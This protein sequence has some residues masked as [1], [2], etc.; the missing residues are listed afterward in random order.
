MHE[1]PRK[2]SSRLALVMLGISVVFGS[3]VA[4]D[5]KGRV[6]GT[7]TASDAQPV[8]G[9]TITMQSSSETESTLS[10]TKG[11][12]AFVS[13]IPDSYVLTV[14]REGYHDETRLDVSVQAD[15]VKDESVTLESQIS[16][17]GHVTARSHSSLVQ[18]GA[19]SD[20]YSL[21]TNQQAV[22]H[23]FGGGN[24]RDSI[25]SSLS[26][27]PGVLVP[28][29]QAPGW[30]QSVL[31]RGG[32]YIQTGYEYDGVPLNRAFDQY[33]ATPLSSL[34]TQEIQAYI[35]GAPIDQ[36]TEGIGGY[37]NQVIKSGS[38]PNS[39]T[40]DVGLGGPAYYNKTALEFSGANGP[41]K[42]F[43]YYIGLSGM[44]FSQ[45]IID[46]SN[47]AAF[48]SRY[49][50]IA[51]YFPGTCGPN[52][53]SGS[54]YANGDSAG[55]IG[56]LPLQPNGYKTWPTFWGEQPAGKDEEA[57][58]NFHFAIPHHTDKGRDDVQF[59]YSNSQYSSSPNT[60]LGSLGSSFVQSNSP[61]YQDAN[62]F[63][64]SLNRP[65]INAQ[66]GNVA[67]IPFPG[68]QDLGIND[69]LSLSQSDSQLN[70]FALEKLAYRRN[71][72]TDAN[73]RLTLYSEQ[74]SEWQNGIVGLY[75]PYAYGAFV[76]DY[77]LTSQTTGLDA[78]FTKQFNAQNLVNFDVSE[79]TTKYR[80]TN[81]Y[82]DSFGGASPIAMLVNAS[83]PTGGCYGLDSSGN[84]QLTDCAASGAA[85]Y[86]LPSVGPLGAGYQLTQSDSA[87]P[88]IDNANT[89]VC[90]NGP[91]SYYTVSN[92]ANA[93][94]NAG[95][96]RFSSFSVSDHL[97][98]T[99]RLAL[100]LGLRY[101]L[102]Q[103]FPSNTDTPGNQLYV[104]TFNQLNCINGSDIASNPT[105][106]GPCSAVGPGYRA[107]NLTDVSHTLT[108]N[109]FSPRFGAAYTLN[110]N[111]ALRF[112]FGRYVQP[113][114]A[115][116][117]QSAN[118]GAF[119][120]SVEQYATYGLNSPT[121]NIVPEVSYNTDFSWEHQFNDNAT[122]MK[123][124]PFYRTTSNEFATIVIDPKTN[125]SAYVNGLNRKSSGV[126]LALRHGDFKKNGLSMMF[127]YT[128]THSLA[129]FIQS[130]TG[131][132]FVSAANQSIQ[133]FNGFTS[134][135]S[136]NPGSGL[137]PQTQIVSAAPCYL[138]AASGSMG[139]PTSSCGV[140]TIANPYW[141][142]KP[143]SLINPNG[144]YAAYDQPLAA[145]A[146]GGS[147]GNTVPN[148]ASLLL[149]YRHNRL[150]V[151]PS[152]QYEAG[153]RYGSPLAS[154]GV[155][156]ASCSAGL[157]SSL[158]DD[159]RYPNGAAAGAGASSPYDASSCSSVM[160]IP[161]PY[162]GS[163]DTIGQY[164]QPSL[165]TFNLQMTYEASQNATIELTASN[166]LY[167]CFGGSKVPW[168][169]GNLG[170][171][172]T[173]AS[174][175]VGNVYN[176]GDAIQQL[177]QSPYTPQINPIVQSNTAGAA[178]PMQLYL[179]VKFKL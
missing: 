86:V 121:N 103:Y 87:N 10:D 38:Y 107:T 4:S 176:P 35:G 152:F 39:V 112:S 21:N 135:C 141:N 96:A 66:I 81:N 128:F 82:A 98:P 148:V 110:A 73:L 84:P 77:N 168:S 8:V 1:R 133:N 114:P 150:V 144:S 7:I 93:S 26:T 33:A 147:T 72:G 75:I 25:T 118:A 3:A 92:G 9:A 170:C 145:G 18:P 76:T 57:V 116:T 99:N 58:G 125:F 130:P 132:S 28:A 83:N 151:A 136:G 94:V 22:S 124:T 108:F 159:P 14:H 11:H 122:S 52:N 62:V 24:E 16:E 63:T 5:I 167:R 34:G 171:N 31:I 79:T 36:Q 88:T 126:E 174:P 138:P 48:A 179:D 134:Y 146:G 43:T 100:D 143:A 173:Q 163:F 172:Y 12:Y 65:L 106:G 37:I 70:E 54:C 165:L 17:I 90:G 41:D 102:F 89:Y 164:V 169:A 55:T 177:A 155:N 61:Y 30:G 104:N 69:P 101:D 40:A 162:T 129:K 120:P 85:S 137:C 175:Y 156:P 97:T 161:N 64:G 178:L 23:A 154:Q 153:A 166:L 44:G 113:A 157:N 109:E 115:G 71:I 60:S 49:A 78:A 158:T 140:G 139:T 91:C 149:H 80:R 29:G 105:A 51:G 45:R 119:Y 32:D 2:L 95:A 15:V 127:G 47:G 131:G 123:V 42:K 19:T 50:P 27:V 6:S 160:A 117:E 53:T 68:H 67:N 56:G 20:M 46:Q 111:N 142:A 59:L 13:L 74:S